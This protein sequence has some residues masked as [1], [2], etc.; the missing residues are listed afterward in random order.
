MA[1]IKYFRPFT[2]LVA[3]KKIEHCTSCGGMIIL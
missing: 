3:I 2:A 1:G